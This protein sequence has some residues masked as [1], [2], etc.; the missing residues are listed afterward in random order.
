MTMTITRRTF[1]KQAGVLAAGVGAS[2]FLLRAAEG[3]PSGNSVVVFILLRGGADGMAICAPYGD[4]DYYKARPTIALP[5]P[6]TAGA[7]S[8]LDL[9]GYFGLHPAFAPMQRAWSDGQL[10]FVH[11]AGSRAL[12]RSHFDAQEFVETGT[13]GVRTTTGWMDRTLMRL[14]GSDVMQGVAFAPVTPRA[15]LGNEPVLVTDDVSE[16]ELHADGWK[17]E[18]ESLLRAM[19]GD[20]DGGVLAAGR[21][22]FRTLDMLRRSPAIGAIPANGA[23]YPITGFGLKLKQAAEVIRADLGT[24]CIFVSLESKFDTHSNQLDCNSLDFP[25][26]AGSL[27]AFHQDLGKLNDRV[28]VVMTSEFGRALYENGSK[29]VDHGTGG[30]MLLMGGRVRGGRVHGAWPGL[31]KDKL[32]EER[33]LDVTTDFRDVFLEIAQKHLKLNDAHTLFPGHTPAATAGL[34]T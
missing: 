10:A 22:A 12:S 2:P 1:L 27:A 33:D 19:Y 34:L 9:D 14:P 5:K 11:A 25:Q 23:R 24:R 17:S 6:R 3:A 4:P 7:D 15:F 18:A 32:F 28:V 31:K 29:G 13:P 16:F 8:L 26:I 30:V 20:G 21:D